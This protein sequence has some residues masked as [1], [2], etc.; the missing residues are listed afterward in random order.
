M[1]IARCLIPVNGIFKTGM[2]DVKMSV[3]AGKNYPWWT[4]F[5]ISELMLSQM[6]DELLQFNRGWPGDAST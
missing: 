5:Y 6:I 1:V 2:I 3:D 4:K